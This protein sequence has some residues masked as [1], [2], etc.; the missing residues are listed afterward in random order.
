MAE[1]ARQRLVEQAVDLGLG[2]DVDAG[3][4]LLEDQ[5]PARRSRASARAPPSA[6]CRRTGSRPAA[7]GRSA[8]RRT[9]RTSSRAGAA[10]RPGA[11]RRAGRRPLAAG[12]RNRFSRTL[13]GM[14][15]LS[16]VR[17]PATKPIPGAHRRAR[18]CRDR[19]SRRRAA[20]RAGVDRRSPNSARPTCSCPAPRRPTRPRISP[21]RS[22]EDRPARRRRS[23]RPAQLERARPGRRRRRGRRP[24][25]AAGR[26]SCVTSSAG[27]VSA[28]GLR[29][30]RRPSRSTV[31]SSAISKTSSS[32]WET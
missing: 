12:L 2:A 10:S 13:S 17:S 11:A 6:G 5:Q 32:R 31:T 23:V 4:R 15:R 8:G 27:V 20:R 25:R 1:P 14:A 19:A 18:A 26:R 3:G 24:A 28:T 16:A 30:T 21:A 9:G 22:V 29:P 7:P